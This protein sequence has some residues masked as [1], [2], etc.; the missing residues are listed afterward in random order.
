MGHYP[1]LPTIATS[2][3]IDIRELVSRK[4]TKGGIDGFSRKYFEKQAQHLVENGKWDEFMDMLALI[5]Y[6]I[7]L[8]P[9]IDDFIDF[10]ALDVFLA[11]KHN[12]RNPVPA[13][14][15]DIYHTL[16]VR[17]EKKRGMLL[18]CL[19]ALYVWFT[20][21]M[22]KNRG[23]VETKN[24]REWAQSIVNLDERSILWY[25]RD[26]ERIDVIYCCGDFPNVPLM[27][28][29]GCI[30]YNPVLASRQFG[31]PMRGPP[32]EESITPFI[33]YNMNPDLKMLNK[34][35]R[36]WD[37]VNRKGKDLG[38]GS[39]ATNKSYNQWLKERIQEVK[40]PFRISTP[41]SGD[42]PTQSTMGSEEIEKLKEALALA[43]EDRKRL[44]KELNKARR[45][46]KTAQKEGA[47]KQIFIEMANKKARVEKECKL[48]TQSC[49]RDAN[50]ELR[51]QKLER[52]KALTKA[53]QWEEAWKESQAVE[54]NVRS[55]LEDLKQ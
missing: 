17:H 45:E 44:K 50:R 27:G 52:D 13:I 8:F 55:Q 22:F 24:D 47:K 12:R 46:C 1:S 39:G 35:R 5:I 49:L 53:K 30:N 6:G 15:S 28:T 25:F 43:E 54:R 9:N 42:I 26:L 31:Y 16:T 23:W 20:T 18:C 41:V 37:H 11:Y 36:A 29:K 10:A 3:K 32:S 51:L 40:L 48:R 2:L 34:I 19:P 4:E 14:L 33:V 7:V 38:A 21:H